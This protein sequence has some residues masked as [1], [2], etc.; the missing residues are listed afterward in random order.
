V[1]G[2]AQAPHLAE[3]DSRALTLLPLGAEHGDEL[4]G[5]DCAIPGAPWTR[6]IQGMI[7]GGL[8]LALLQEGFISAAGLWDHRVLA[9]LV[10]WRG[11]PTSA[12]TWRVPILAVR[13]GYRR[14]GHGLELKTH[15]LE[16]ARVE[17]IRA[18][19]SLVHRH[20]TPML[21]LNRKLGA[22]VEPYPDHHGNYV[23]C[24]IAI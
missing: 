13:E 6:T 7:R 2:T 14:C 1:R 21:V 17:Q 5:F 16:A 18:V 8:P 23:V 11:D 22:V 20:N 19:V 10:A 4:R 3:V 12:H 15:V 9:G 24:T